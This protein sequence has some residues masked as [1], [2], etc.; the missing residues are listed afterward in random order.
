MEKE[1]NIFSY[2][3]PPEMETIET[4]ILL[5]GGGMANC[6]AAYEACRWATPKGIKVTLVDKAALDRSGTVAMGLSAI[7]TYIGLNVGENTVEDY[8]NYVRGDLMGIIREDI[9]YDIGRHVDDS[10]YLFDEWGLPLWKNEGEEEKKLGDGARCVRSGRWQAMI[11]GESYKVIVAEAAKKVLEYNREKTGMAQNLYERVFITHL[12]LDEKED[13]RIAGAVGFSVRDYKC[14]LFKAKVVLNA[15]GGGVNTYRPRATDEGLG[16]TWYPVWNS[17]STTTMGLLVG[18]ELTMMENV[19]V[20][21]RFKDGYGPVGTFF[22]YLKCKATNALGED[23]T[24]S[25][26]IKQYAPYCDIK[27]V[28]TCLRNHQM[29]EELKAG[30]G[31]VF[32]HTQDAIQAMRAKDAKLAKEMENAAWEDFLDMTIAQAGVWATNNIAPEEKPSEMMPTEPYFIGSHAACSGFWVSGPSDIAPPEWQW[33]YNRMTTVKGLFTAGDG[34]GASGHKF[35]SGS[36]ADGRIAAKAMVAFCLDHSGF[37]PTITKP[38]EEFAKEIC[39]PF[40]LYE[41]YKGYTTAADINPNY[42]RPKQLQP[43]V[44]KIMDEY[45]GGV[46]TWYITS[47]TMMEKGL[48]LLEMAKEDSDRLAAENLHELMRAWENRHRILTAEAHIRHML[49]R[50]ETRYPGYYYRADFPKIDD[51]NWKCFVN[52]KYN[53]QTGKFE[54]FKRE[55]KQLVV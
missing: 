36:H 10:V 38:I 25:P 6:G 28:P 33:G 22:L 40:E 30:K 51:S 53:S 4:D 24:Q 50:E 48:E 1:V 44:M 14:Y 11:S 55:Y 52:S 18:A 39:L 37:T 34:V 9:V 17:S 41:K 35:S 45:A 49:F 31:P 19:F 8:V 13:N 54:I 20:P 26:V 7:N 23:Y 16:R 15:C 42:I 21:T 32:M 12:I 2:A 47:R 5:V 43:R 27:P 3:K 29:I 46:S